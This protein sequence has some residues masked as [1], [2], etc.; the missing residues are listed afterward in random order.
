MGIVEGICAG[1]ITFL[2][3]LFSF[4]VGYGIAQGIAKDRRDLNE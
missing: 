3:L 1:A 4:L 2:A